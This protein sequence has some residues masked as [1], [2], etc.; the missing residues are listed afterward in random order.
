M[1]MYM[2]MYVYVYVYMFCWPKLNHNDGWNYHWSCSTTCCFL[3]ASDFTQDLREL[4]Q[5]GGCPKASLGARAGRF[6]LKNWNCDPHMEDGYPLVANFHGGTWRQTIWCKK[7]NY[8]SLVFTIFG[9]THL[10][11]ISIWE[12]DHVV[13]HQGIALHWSNTDPV[14][15][16]FPTKLKIMI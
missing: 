12:T 2:Y 10:T 15:P 4:G 6:M 11:N 13:D 14:D 1:Y 16:R 3:F 5:D 9:Q 7:Y 8:L